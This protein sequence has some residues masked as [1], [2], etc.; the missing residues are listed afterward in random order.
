MLLLLLFLPLPLPLLLFSVLVLRLLLAQKRWEEEKAFEM[1][2]PAPGSAAPEQEKHFVTF[3]YPYM[4]GLLHLG[5]TFS[6]SKTEFSMGYERLKGKKTLW[7]FGFHCTGMPIQAAADNLISQEE[8]KE[9]DAEASKEEEEAEMDPTKFKGKKSKAA[10]KKGK[11][12]QW[13]V[14]ESMDI[15]RETIPRFVD[16]VYW[17]QYFP[18]IAKQD[19]IEM[20]VKVDWRRSF[21]TTNVNPYYDSFIQWQFHK[22]RKLEKVSFGKRYSIFSPID[23]Q[24]CADHDRATGEGVGPQEYVLIKMEI[25]TLPPALQQVDSTSSLPSCSS[26]CSCSSLLLV[27]LPPSPL[28]LTRTQLEGKKV[29][30][31]AATL[32]PETMYGQTNCWVL[33][34]EKDAIVGERA[35]RNMAFQGLTPEVTRQQ[36]VERARDVLLAVR[37]GQGS[38]ESARKRPGGTPAQLCPIYTL[39]MLTISMKKGTGVVTSVPSDAP[40]DYQALMDLKNKPA[41]R[42]KYGVKDEWV[43][44]FDLIPIIEIPYKRDDAP[45][46]AE[47]ELTDLAAKVACEEYKVASQNDKEKL[48]L[49]KAKT[50]KLGFYEGKMTIGDFKGMPVQEA[51]NRVK[52]QM[53]EENNAYSYAEP[54]KEVMS[55]SGNECVVALTDQWYIKYGEEEWRKQVEEHLQKDLNCYSDDT[56]SKFEA[57][58]S[59]LGEWG[60]SRSFGL[61]TLLPWDKQFVIES[62]SDSTIYMAYYTFCH[63]LHQGPFD[64]SVPGP[65]GVV[66]KDL[67]EEVWDYIL[68]DGPQPKDSKVPQETLE[69]MKQEFNYWYPVDLR[70]SGKDLIQNHLTFFLYNHAAIFPKKHWPRSIRTNGHVLLNNEKMSK[71]TGNFKTLKQ[72]I[73]EYSADGMRF[74]LALAGDGNEDANFEHD[75]ANAAILKLTNELQFVEKSLTELDKMRTG[76]LDL[77]IDKNFDNEINRLVKSAD[78]C[79]RRMQFR[80]SV[81]EGWDKLQ[82][83]RDKYRAMAGPIG[84][85]AELIKKF[86]TCQTLVIAPICPHYSEYVWGLLGHKESVMEA[87]WPEVGDVDPLLVRMNSYFDKTLSDIRAK[88]DKARAKKAVAKATVYV[89]D[90]FLDWQQAA[91][92]VL[93]SDFKKNMMSFPELAPFKAQTKVL[94]PFAAFSIDEFEARGPEA[95]ELKVPYDEVRLLTDSIEYLKGEL[96]VEEIE[97]TKWPP[98][99]PAVL[100]NLRYEC[101]LISSRSSSPLAPPLLPLL[102]SRSFL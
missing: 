36:R 4:N 79:Y 101:A 46:G 15:P 71:S 56:K 100:K 85:H 30:L 57:A 95:F 7:P 62:L 9:A 3:P 88:T 67:T 39:P 75:V 63:I 11:G 58:L 23:N 24:I 26:S 49:A 61:G 16:P 43:L 91:L 77:F 14:L 74:A 8:E 21:I 65:A 40:D 53:L 6:L 89:A 2:A 51:K 42:E 102:S 81:I 80:E 69:R 68:L 98:S 94:M 52:A 48:V 86:I 55:R 90:E 29:V 78:E 34:H 54:E 82:N 60:C 97:V 87:R 1:D 13:Q 27:L 5:H 72:A 44:P 31:L 19:L 22:L 84:M 64:G 47:P 59:W 38:D 41:L 18:P 33:P 17:L 35:A 66:A 92:N 25:L 45:E 50:Y 99:D 28:P 32:R 73:G 12:N 93:R 96:S 10:A 83:A 20:G 37:R 76:E 70:V